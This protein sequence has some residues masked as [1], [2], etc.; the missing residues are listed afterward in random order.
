MCKVL[1]VSRSGFYDYMQRFSNY[2]PDREEQQLERRTKDIFTKS[3]NTYGSRRM[4][5]ELREEGFDLGRHRVRTLMRNLGLVARTPRRFKVTTDSRHSYRVAANLLDRQFD[6][7]LPDRVWAAD[8]SYVWT[9]EGWLYLAIVMDLATRQIVGWSIDKHMRVQLTLSMAYWR[10]KPAAGLLH[11]SDRGVQYA[12]GQYQDN[13]KQYSMVASMSRKGNCWDNSPVERFFRSLKSERL[14]YCRF[15]SRAAGRAEV[16]DYITYYN[17]YR[18]HS[19]L[20]YVSPME[21]ER[22]LV[23]MAS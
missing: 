7:K 17:A 20:G 10:R 11:H 14:N 16:L 8:I 21:F 22:L 3:G 15:V 1:K 5:I 18:R 19:T 23:P 9:L 6:Q 4:V 13:L 2:E 12:C